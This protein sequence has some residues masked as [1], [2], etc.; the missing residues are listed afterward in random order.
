MAG[1][2]DDRE[3]CDTHI[4]HL[5]RHVKVWRGDYS[6][7]LPVQE[8]ELQTKLPG[9]KFKTR[10]RKWFLVQCIVKPWSSSPQDVTDAKHLNRNWMNSWKKN[11][12]GY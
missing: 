4:H 5:G 2:R 9:G 8:Y 7:S 3:G 6:P 12:L 11:P 10:K 1:K